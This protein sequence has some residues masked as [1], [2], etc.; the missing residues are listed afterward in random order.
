MSTRQGIRYTYGLGVETVSQCDAATN[1]CEHRRQSKHI[2]EFEHKIIA[3]RC[4]SI[5]SCDLKSKIKKI[6]KIKYQQII[7]AIAFA[8]RC[9]ILVRWCPCRIDDSIRWLSRSYLHKIAYMR[10]HSPLHNCRGL[11]CGRITLLLAE[12]YA[13]VLCVL[14][15][16]LPIVVV[17]FYIYKILW[18]IKCNKNFSMPMQT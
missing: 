5:P 1:R 11:F 18:C 14:S 4:K 10:S 6:C 8:L 16:I 13:V 7:G 12:Y 2:H 9:A 17:L 15:A 3:L